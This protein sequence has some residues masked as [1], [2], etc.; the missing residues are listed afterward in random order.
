MMLP[1]GDMLAADIKNC[2]IIVIK[3]PAHRPWRLIGQASYVCAHDPPVRY[4]SP[5]GAFR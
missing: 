1:S 2:R 5:N 4:G 3:P